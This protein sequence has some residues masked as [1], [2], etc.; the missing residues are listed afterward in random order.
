VELVELSES[1]PPPFATSI[2]AVLPGVMDSLINVNLNVAKEEALT[3]G[4]MDK[5]NADLA[6]QINDLSQN[7]DQ[8]TENVDQIN[9]R[10]D[11]TNYNPVF[12]V[13]IS[14]ENTMEN[15]ITLVL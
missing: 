6:Q 11:R 4:C 15:T 3:R 2:N 7:V 1:M 10:L 12:R 14:R 8:I 5:A 13:T 9:D